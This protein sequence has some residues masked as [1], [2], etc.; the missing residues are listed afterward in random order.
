MGMEGAGRTFYGTLLSGMEM[1]Y[2]P[3][4]SFYLLKMLGAVSES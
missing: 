2:S 4:V 1:G 3:F